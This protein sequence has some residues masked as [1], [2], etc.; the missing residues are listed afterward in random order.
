[1]TRTDL[2]RV[3]AIIRRSDPIEHVQVR[4]VDLERRMDRVGRP[5]QEERRRPCECSIPIPLWLLG[6]CKR[7]S[8]AMVFQTSQAQFLRLAAG[9][10]PNAQRRLC[11]WPLP[12]GFP[13]LFE[14]DSQR[15]VAAYRRPAR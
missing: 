15:G 8:S 7:L 14:Y 2:A 1:M 13:K 9:R 6:A 3:V 12:N 4:R 11:C 5:E 10:F